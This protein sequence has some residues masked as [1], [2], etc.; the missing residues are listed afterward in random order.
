MD[1][2]NFN[3]NSI[4]K[5]L[6]QTIIIHMAS[7]LFRLSWI[8][9]CVCFGH[10]RLWNVNRFWFK[11][12][13]KLKTRLCFVYL[14]SKSCGAID[15]SCF[16]RAMM[17]DYYYDSILYFILLLESKWYANIE[18]EKGACNPE[19]M[20]VIMYWQVLIQIYLK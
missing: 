9:T 11:A 15:F 1:S 6:L 20:K 14:S 18:F 13:S 19:R 16:A 8:V 3:R 10:I 2:T 4:D 17:F 12:F 5:F 7:T